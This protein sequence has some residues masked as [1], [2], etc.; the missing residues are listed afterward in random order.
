MSKRDHSEIN[1]ANAQHSTGPN[2]E[3]GKQRSSLNALRHGLTGQLVVMPNEDHHLYESHKKAFRDEYQPQGV[4]EENL[5]HALADASWRLNRVAPLETNLLSIAYSPADLVQGLLDQA[6]AMANLSLHSQRLSRQFERTV[7]Q[8]RALQ[9][10]RR[11]KEAHEL[12]ERVTSSNCIKPRDKP[13]IPRPM[14]SF[15]QKPKST[16]RSAPATANA[17]PKKPTPTA[18]IPPPRNIHTAEDRRVS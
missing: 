18:T 12:N 10:T 13:T 7:T 14:A 16:N 11:E 5:V 8:L 9:Q 2:T 15:F 3:A 1:K 17:W 4:T 6:K